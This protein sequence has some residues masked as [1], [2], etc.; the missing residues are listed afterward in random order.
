MNYDNC[1]IEVGCLDNDKSPI[2]KYGFNLM[3]SEATSTT[4]NLKHKKLKYKF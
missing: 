1:L 2:K 3:L 4:A